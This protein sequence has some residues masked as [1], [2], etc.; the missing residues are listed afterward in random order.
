LG[1]HSPADIVCGG[2]SGVLVLSM[3]MQ[4]STYSLL[5]VF[6]FQCFCYFANPVVEQV[7][8]LKV[9]DCHEVWIHLLKFCSKL[10]KRALSS[11]IFNDYSQVDDYVDYYISQPW[12]E[13][14]L[15]VIAFMLLLLCIHPITEAG[16]PSFT[17]T[18]RMRVVFRFVSARFSANSFSKSLFL[19]K[20]CWKL[21][22]VLKSAKST[23]KIRI[24]FW[25]RG[26][27][28]VSLTQL[29]GCARLRG[30]KVGVRS[31]CCTR[32]CF[33]TAADRSWKESS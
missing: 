18:V 2:I 5:L 19:A 31:Y 20:R 23:P 22:S 27:C 10:E 30:C 9:I 28:E 6:F 29:R 11:K 32:H 7:G 33:A 14:P 21:R 8:L 26:C 17:D 1:V 15:R 24:K 13:Q 25:K 16:N 12:L 3:W 4:V